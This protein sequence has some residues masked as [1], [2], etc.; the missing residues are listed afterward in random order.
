MIKN[1]LLISQLFT[2]TIFYA[3]D[4]FGYS[5]TMEINTVANQ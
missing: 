4:K 5:E 1:K 2:A 3:L